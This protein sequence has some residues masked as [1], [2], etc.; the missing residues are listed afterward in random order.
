MCPVLIEVG[1]GIIQSMYF[2]DFGVPV[3]IPGGDMNADSVADSSDRALIGQCISQGIYVASADTNLDG[4]VDFQD[5]A[6]FLSRLSGASLPYGEMQWGNKNLNRGFVGAEHVVSDLIDMRVRLLSNDLGHWLQR[7]PV[8][9]GDGMNAYEYARSQGGVLVDL[10]GEHTNL[11]ECMREAIDRF[12]DEVADI[13]A[14]LKM[15]LEA[16]V[17]QIITAD[18]PKEH[19]EERGRQAQDQ[20]QADRDDCC[21]TFKDRGGRVLPGPGFVPGRAP[22]KVPCTDLKKAGSDSWW[23]RFKRG[24]RRAGRGAGRGVRAALSAPLLLIPFPDHWLGVYHCDEPIAIA[25]DPCDGIPESSPLYELLGCGRPGP[26]VFI[27]AIESE[28]VGGSQNP[29]L[30]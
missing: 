28:S 11:A 4:V 17:G 8:L 23:E 25:G 12:K 30:K 21:S 10:F 9:F 26:D 24:A 18:N 2:S 6:D 13:M 29:G 5:A 3:A 14:E 19:A 20:L 1:V 22:V 27:F 7:D 16:P 15:N